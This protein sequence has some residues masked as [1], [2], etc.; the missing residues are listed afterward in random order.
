MFLMPFID[1]DKV[2]PVVV[3]REG[4]FWKA[5]ND[6]VPFVKLVDF[7]FIYSEGR[8]R[9]FIRAY[10]FFKGLRADKVIWA[11]NR[12]GDFFIWEMLASWLVTHFKMYIS[13]HNI[14][15]ESD[16]EGNSARRDY[17]EIKKTYSN[18]R[19]SFYLRHLFAERI[20]SVS[21]DITSNLTNYW[22]IP[23]K[24]IITQSRGI[25]RN[26]F[27][28]NDNEKG[29]L[30]RE[31]H[32]SDNEKLFLAIN[33]IAGEKRIDRLLGAF[34]LILKEGI[35][36]QLLIAGDG[37]LFNDFKMR[38]DKNRLLANRVIFLGHC[39]SISRYIM[40]VD[41]LLLA[42]DNEG[43][44]SV[45]KEA[46]SC[47]IIPIVTDSPGTKEISDE[48]IISKRNVFAF[49]RKILSAINM[50]QDEIKV[51]RDKMIRE[52]ETK[53]DFDICSKNILKAFDL[54]VNE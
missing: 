16:E 48:I 24:K 53:Y 13:H 29:N 19:Y 49:K 45:I 26:I 30:R 10:R 25:N 50:S 39:A 1:Q 15:S 22:G 28:L 6:T 47:G 20:V 11:H 5:Y 38:V 14:P 31:F 12:M 54:P 2:Q 4:E 40:G 18:K 23:L 17:E 52:I 7:P 36:A 21:Q 43:Q 32:C 27:F 42:S 37:P 34:A 46:M 51:K 9:R 33:R 41:Y 35:C 8:F 3:A 44:S